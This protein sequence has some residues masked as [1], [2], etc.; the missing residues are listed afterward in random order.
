MKKYH[1][2]GNIFIITT[3]N[4]KYENLNFIKDIC[5]DVDGFMMVKTN[6]LE[7]VLYNKDTSIAPMCGNGMRCFIQYCYDHNLLESDTKPVPIQYQ[8]AL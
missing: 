1:G 8:K 7:M 3:Y 2:C 5:K 4:K 6:P